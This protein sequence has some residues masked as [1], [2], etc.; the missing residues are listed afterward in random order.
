M[1]CQFNKLSTIHWPG[2]FVEGFK[3]FLSLCTAAEQLKL[4]KTKL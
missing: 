4:L 1:I 3:C 2:V